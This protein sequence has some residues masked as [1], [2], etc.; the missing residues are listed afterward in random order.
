MGVKWKNIRI[1]RVKKTIQVR[2]KQ[3]FN[4]V[5]SEGV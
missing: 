2:S 5:M 3:A 1:E 4:I